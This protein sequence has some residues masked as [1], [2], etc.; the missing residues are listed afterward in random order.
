MF[1]VNEE[2]TQRRAEMDA[3]A[4]DAGE[5]AQSTPRRPEL[6][7]DAEESTPEEHGYGYGV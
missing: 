1:A 7:L 5:D 4:P 3:S 6:K 2:T